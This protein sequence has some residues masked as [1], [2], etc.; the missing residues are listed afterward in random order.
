MA[1]QTTIAAHFNRSKRMSPVPEPTSEHEPTTSDHLFHLANRV[2][3][4]IQLLVVLMLLV[5]VGTLVFY[6]YLITQPQEVLGGASTQLRELILRLWEQVTP[7]AG[8][9]ASLVAP[10]FILIFALGVL[11]RLGR[12]GAAPFEVTKLFSDLPSTLALLIIA[13]ICL[14]PLAGLSIPDV[15]NNIALVVVGF[16]FGKRKSEGDA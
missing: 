2:I 1:S 10:I 6:G 9:F 11:H 16:Y 8:R 3:S 7:Y 14:L 15:L 13:T 5:V 12:S 4:L